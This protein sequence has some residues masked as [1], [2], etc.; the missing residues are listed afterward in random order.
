VIVRLKEFM[1]IRILKLETYLREISTDLGGTER[2]WFEI[3]DAADLEMLFEKALKEQPKKIA[4][5]NPE[6]KQ[7]KFLGIHS[8]IH[9][10]FICVSDAADACL[11]GNDPPG[12]RMCDS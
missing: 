2:S 7:Q 12:F 11:V 8:A 3:S 6:W 5:V 10:D 9:T 4:I 1:L